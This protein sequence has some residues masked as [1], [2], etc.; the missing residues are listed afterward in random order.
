MREYVIKNFGFGK[1]DYDPTTKKGT[2]PEGQRDAPGV[3]ETRDT[4]R[5]YEGLTEGSS[6][7]WRDPP[8]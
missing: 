4:L 8:K 6:R 5:M 3:D 2:L 7:K 1:N